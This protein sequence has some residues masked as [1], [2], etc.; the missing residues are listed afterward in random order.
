MGRRGLPLFVARVSQVQIRRSM[1]SNVIRP[2]RNSIA[3]SK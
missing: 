2:M 1:K 3:E